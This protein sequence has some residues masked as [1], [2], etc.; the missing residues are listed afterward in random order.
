MSFTVTMQ[1]NVGADEAGDWANRSAGDAG[2]ATSV[3]AATPVAAPTS[4]AD[5][6]LLIRLHD[7]RGACEAMRSEPVGVSLADTRTGEGEL[8]YGTPALYEGICFTVPV[9]D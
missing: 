1:L 7:L 2:S 9:L 4:S 5:D 3:D 6:E 8:G